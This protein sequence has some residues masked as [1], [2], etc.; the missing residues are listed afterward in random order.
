[1]GSVAI[2]SLQTRHFRGKRIRLPLLD[3]SG[4]LP[5]AIGSLKLS[6]ATLWELVDAIARGVKSRRWRSVETMLLVPNLPIQANR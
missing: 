4:I 5:V 6:E 2:A 1:M 3:D